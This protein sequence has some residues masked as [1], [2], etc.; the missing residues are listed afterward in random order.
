M[1]QRQQA[2]APDPGGGP[3]QALIQRARDGDLAAFDQLI[4]LHQDRL[5]SVASRLMGSEE[6]AANAVQEVFL[7]AFRRLGA[8]D[9]RAS[10]FVWLCGAMTGKLRA[11]W[12]AREP[13]ESARTEGFEAD[14]DPTATPILEVFVSPAPHPDEASDNGGEIA[15][16]LEAQLLALE[17]E[18][19][20]A[21]V[22]RLVEGLSIEAVAE[23]LAEAPEIVRSRVARGR[24]ILRERMGSFLR[25]AP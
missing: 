22:L 2:A 6:D 8:F 14:E 11:W 19:R 4:E 12:A 9:D 17:P 20:A 21:V 18:V 13:L 16:L 5:F 25:E 3:E 10:V 15:G 1:I 24:R 23:V 7:T